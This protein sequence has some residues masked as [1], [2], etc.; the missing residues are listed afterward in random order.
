MIKISLNGYTLPVSPP[1][2]NVSTS[3]NNTQYNMVKND[4]VIIGRTQLKTVTFESFFPYNARP[5]SHNNLRLG[6]TWVKLI[7]HLRD[8]RE[9]IRLVI[10]GEISENFECVINKFDYSVSRGKDIY[11]SLELMEYRGIK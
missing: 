6:Y 11:Y 4:A 1:E 9:P 3:Q 2:V 8:K 7:N 10:T 5:Y